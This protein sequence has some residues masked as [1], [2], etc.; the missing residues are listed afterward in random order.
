[1]DKDTGE[2]KF[3]NEE[4]G[5]GFIIRENGPEIFFHVTGLIYSTKP[6]K[7]DKVRFNIITAQKGPKA[8]DIDIR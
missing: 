2:V 5:Y 1:M 4:K 3:F 8:I 6:M 7:G